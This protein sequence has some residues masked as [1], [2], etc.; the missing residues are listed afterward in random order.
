MEGQSREGVPYSRECDPW[1]RT[2]GLP[3]GGC[4]AGSVRWTGRA[5]PQ[6][7][8]ERGLGQE[9]RLR[10]QRGT[11]GRMVLLDS[12]QGVGLSREQGGDGDRDPGCGMTGQS[13][14]RQPEAEG[15]GGGLPVLPRSRACSLQAAEPWRAEGAED[16]SQV[17]A[18]SRRL[19]WPRR[20]RPQHTPGIRLHQPLRQ[21]ISKLKR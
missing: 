8:V 19:L 1:S 12:T 16:V 9:W 18:W 20:H 10:E 5:S 7:V 11:L 4:L 2:W 3:W 21:P 15:A 14:G 6:K 13:E 17:P